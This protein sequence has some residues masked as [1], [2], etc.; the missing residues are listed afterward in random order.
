M[1]VHFREDVLE[2]STEVDE[3]G[4]TKLVLRGTAQKDY[5]IQDRTASQ[6]KMAE[7]ARGARQSA[8]PP[9]PMGGPADPQFSPQ[10]GPMP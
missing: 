9:L 6:K 5:T 2:K 1:C 7:Q 8:L 10:Y 3:N 4:V